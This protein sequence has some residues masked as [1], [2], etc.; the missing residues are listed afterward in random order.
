MKPLNQ[1]LNLLCRILGTVLFVSCAGPAMQP[2]ET[3]VPPQETVAAPSLPSSSGGDLL[4]KLYVLQTVPGVVAKG[5][6][7][8]RNTASVKEGSFK[9]TIA[10]ETMSMEISSKG[11]KIGEIILRDNTVS[12][13]PRLKDEYLEYMFAV[14]LRDSVTWW[15]I[16]GYQLVSHEASYVLRN[17][18][19]KVYIS[20]QNLTPDRQVIRMMNFKAVEV[21]YA[22]PRDYGFAVLPANIRFSYEGYECVLDIDRMAVKDAFRES[23]GRDQS[24]PS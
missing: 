4:A 23:G 14:I 21:Q 13:N 8:L 18:W 3:T 16:T 24:Q 6:V 1:V 9:L 19:K 12:M 22:S 20:R 5:T 15:N 17:S 2:P 7:S 11:F 10:G